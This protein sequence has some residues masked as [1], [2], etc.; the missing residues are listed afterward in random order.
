MKG[1]DSETKE[2]DVFCVP[3]QGWMVECAS[4]EDAVSVKNADAILSGQDAFDYSSAE[5]VTLATT[6]KRYGRQSAA[7]VLTAM[8][9]RLRAAMFLRDRVRYE[10][11]AER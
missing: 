11:P 10:R 3:L 4:V 1:H 9:A 8:A 5:L 6:L 2:A 7:D